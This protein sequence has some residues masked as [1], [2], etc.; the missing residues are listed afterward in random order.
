MY[1]SCS[2]FHNKY[3][4]RHLEGIAILKFEKFNL[5]VTLFQYF[6]YYFNYLQFK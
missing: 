3:V 5:L 1:K 6:F 2:K 4:G